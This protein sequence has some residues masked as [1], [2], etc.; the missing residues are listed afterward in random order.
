MALLSVGI[1]IAYLDRTNMSIALASTEFRRTFC[2]QRIRPRFDK[3]G[4]F[5]L[6][7]AFANSGRNASGSLF[8]P[9]S[10]RHLLRRLESSIGKHSLA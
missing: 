5:L 8:G 7:R 1:A 6:L 10:L 3:F 9:S 2:S 4:L